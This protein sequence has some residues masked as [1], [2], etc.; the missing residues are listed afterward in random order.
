M[1]YLFNFLFAVVIITATYAQPGTL[2][3]SFGDDG[4]VLGQGFMV[5]EANAIAIQQDGK[6]IACGG[7]GY[8]NQGGFLLIRYNPD[9]SV[10]S[11]FGDAGRVVTDFSGPIDDAYGV[12]VQPDGKI[13]AAGQV[14]RNIDA[15]V[16]RY[17]PNGKPDSTFGINGI[18]ITELL[19]GDDYVSSMVLQP[20]GK[21]L[22]TGTQKTKYAFTIRYLPNGSLDE[23]FGDNGKVLTFFDNVSEISSIAVQPDGKIVTAGIYDI[24]GFTQMLLIRYTANG[25]LDKGFGAGGIVKMK[26][27]TGYQMSG[28]N[29]IILQS[30]GKIVVAGGTYQQYD[31][32]MAL[33][34]FESNGMPDLSFGNEGKVITDF[35]RNVSEAKAVLLQP[36]GKIV[37]T[38]SVSDYVGTNSIFALARYKTDGS[39]DSS[40]GTDGLQTTYMEGNAQSYA[41]VLQEDGKIILLGDSYIYPQG[42]T[43]ALARY[44]GGKLNNLPE[45]AKIQKWQ[46][47]Y[48]FTWNSWP[49][50]KT[51]YYS[52]GRST[53]ASS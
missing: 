1:K 13:L 12:V 2:D 31:I 24:Y 34:R 17:L 50:K 15:G 46:G 5:S 14:G 25:I 38:G 18:A 22:V 7:G 32:F 47:H 30:D 26:F 37:A 9:G 27:I 29:G 44:N 33:A 11:S 16:I 21:I 41:S 43:L 35:K 20:D 39:L 36:D 6:I 19:G 48:G 45:F 28:L 3:N 49:G 40:F 42:S 23:S 4:K 10:D 8:G 53:N 51:T 52:V